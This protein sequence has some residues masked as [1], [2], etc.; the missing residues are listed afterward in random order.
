M[1]KI[2]DNLKRSVL[3]YLCNHDRAPNKN[4]EEA[5]G[6]EG[7]YITRALRS[8]G[9]V[10]ITSSSKDNTKPRSLVRD[11]ETFN[12]LLDEFVG[13]EHLEDFLHSSYVENIGIHTP[14]ID[15]IVKKAISNHMK[16]A[17]FMLNVFYPD[18]PLTEHI[19]L[20]L[21][22][23]ARS[24]LFLE[25]CAI[26]AI[27][28]LAAFTSEVDQSS[29]YDENKELFQ[30]MATFLYAWYDSKTPTA[31]DSTDSTNDGGK[32]DLIN[33][34]PIEIDPNFKPIEKIPII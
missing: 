13:T 25:Q 9:S 15:Q 7:A 5:L 17:R 24:K 32:L 30:L 4:I 18:I 27:P 3:L 12:I 33:F 31:F 16:T 19:N 34:E 2:D 14:E 11:P 10:I 20:A 26:L 6:V 1:V 29:A 23:D 28:I 21:S 8:L 22:S